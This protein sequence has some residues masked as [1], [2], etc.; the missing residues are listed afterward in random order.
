M[1]IFAY[2]IIPHQAPEFTQCVVPPELFWGENQKF[3]TGL[4][5]GSH[6]DGQSDVPSTSWKIE[7]VLRG[8]GEG[9]R[10]PWIAPA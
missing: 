4:R 1:G 3:Y 9:M 8:L 10:E 7:F 2:A 6:P 5:G